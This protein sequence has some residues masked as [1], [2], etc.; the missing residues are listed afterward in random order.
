MTTRSIDA[1]PRDDA[2]NGWAH[3]LPAR[4]PTPALKGAVTADWLEKR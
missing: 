2:T 1:L 3:S 4:H